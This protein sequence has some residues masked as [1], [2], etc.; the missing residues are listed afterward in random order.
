MTA[1][2]AVLSVLSVALLLA[3]IGLLYV[4]GTVAGGFRR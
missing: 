2:I 4:L 3:I 1:T